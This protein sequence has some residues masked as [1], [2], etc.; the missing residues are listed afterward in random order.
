ML[1]SRIYRDDVGRLSGQ[2]SCTAAGAQPRHQHRSQP[3]S[4]MPSGPTSGRQPA[5]S[6]MSVP[7]GSLNSSPRRGRGGCPLARRPQTASP[8]TRKTGWWQ[9]GLERPDELEMPSAH[10][11]GRQR[12][13][14]TRGVP[15][16]SSGRMTRWSLKSGAEAQPERG[17]QLPLAPA[18]PTSVRDS[19][20]GPWG[21][22]L[23]RHRM[24]RA[25]AFLSA[26]P[27]REEQDALNRRAR[28]GSGLTSGPRCWRRRC[29]CGSR[30]GVQVIC[31]K[32][33]PGP[34]QGQE[35]ATVGKIRPPA[36]RQESQI[37]TE[38]ELLP[39]RDEKKRARLPISTNCEVASR[40]AP[41]RCLS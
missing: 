23:A 31:M 9:E 13:R 25:A 8:V 5:P 19:A 12:R 15:R 37:G 38:P 41:Q 1:L 26:D 3:A 30:T 24:P 10:V 32:G 22:E 35:I 2:S 29:R 39:T 40:C 16:A 33:G 34:A 6:R 28:R 18:P 36:G 14:A 11:P 20:R 27:T 4:S 17:D 7:L 21:F